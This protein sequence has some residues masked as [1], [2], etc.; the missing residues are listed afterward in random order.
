MAAGA[1]LIR[2]SLSRPEL[3]N[4]RAGGCSSSRADE[5]ALALQ[6]AAEF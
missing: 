6:T 1:A 4:L 3:V 5:R 2:A